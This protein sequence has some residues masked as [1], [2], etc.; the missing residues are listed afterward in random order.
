MKKTLSTLLSVLFC[1]TTFAQVVPQGI[2]YQAVARDATGVELANQALTVQLS[3]ITGSSTGPVSWQETHAVTTN[4]FGVFTAV[5]GQGASTGS[6][7]SATFEE[8]DWG[9]ATHY[10]KVEINTGSGYVDMGTNEL[11][12]VPYALM[13]PDDGD[14]EI[15]AYGSL[16]NV[17]KEWVRIIGNDTLGE[18]MIAPNSTTANERSQ[19]LLMEDYY[20][21]YGMNLHYDGSDNKFKIFG[22]NGAAEVGPWLTI[23]RD[24]GQIQMPA[25][26]QQNYVFT[27]DSL[28]NASWTDPS[29]VGVFENDSGVTSNANGDYTTDDFVFGSSSLDYDGTNNVRMFLDKSNGAFRAGGSGFSFLGTIDEENWDEDSLGYCSFAVGNGNKATNSFGSSMGWGNTS[30]G[31]SSFS[32]GVLTKALGTGSSSFGLSTEASSF[33]SFV[34]GRNNIGGGDATSWVDTDP[35]FEIGIGSDASNKDNAMTVLKNGDI[36]VGSSSPTAKFHVNGDAGGGEAFRVQVAGSTKLSVSDQGGVAIGSFTS[37]QPAN[38]LYVSGNVGIGTTN[39]ATGYKVSVNGKVMCEELRVELSGSW[40]DYVFAN[41]YDLI[42][43]SEV[44]NYINQNKHLPGVPSAKEVKKGGIAMGEMTTVLM[45]KI[46][47]LTLY[48]IEANKNQ[49]KANKRIEQL[50]KEIQKLK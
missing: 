7:S 37:L 9:S 12:S 48:L 35:L 6:G 2:N 21:T 20:G 29:F 31:L 24:N 5:I 36:G 44:E 25:G 28:G 19:L 30:S 4:D 10:M 46:E 16:E 8:V 43:L 18:L 45:E 33:Y 14:W 41:N 27:T 26:A 11:L 15:G 13:A 42:S 40:P 39:I 17:Q 49:I 23:A 34:L 22:N 38:G 1:A 47:E 3:V 50:E 32:S